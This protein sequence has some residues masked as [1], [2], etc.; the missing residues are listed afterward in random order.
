MPELVSQHKDD[1]LLVQF[2]SQKI[3]SDVLIA[4]IGREL[5]E[6]A[7]QANGKMV[8]DFQGVTFMSSAMIGK[9]VLLNKKCKA[10]STTVKLC[11]IA[12]SIMEVFEIT[13]L[14]KVFSIYESMEEALKSFQKKG[15]FG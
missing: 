14:N 11:N 3:L 6:L 1:V 15:W 7:D 8:L 5:L 10:N 9:I 2:T 4:Q 12:P 13:R